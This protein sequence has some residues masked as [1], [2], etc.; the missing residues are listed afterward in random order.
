M[1]VAGS[2]YAFSPR[3]FTVKVEPGTPLPEPEEL[4]FVPPPH[5]AAAA[6]PRSARA[7][8]IRR[9]RLPLRMAARMRAI[10]WRARGAPSPSSSLPD[11]ELPRSCVRLR[12]IAV[13]MKPMSGGRG[14][15]TALREAPRAV[16]PFT[17]WGRS[18][19]VSRP[20][21]CWEFRVAAPARV[22]TLAGRQIGARLQWVGDGWGASPKC[23]MVSLGVWV[24]ARTPRRS[25]DGARAMTAPAPGKEKAPAADRGGR[26][27]RLDSGDA[28]AACW[29]WR[30]PGRG[31]RSSRT[32][33]GPCTR[34]CAR[35][36]PARP[37]TTCS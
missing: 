9:M 29:S 20:R 13:P 11:A 25:L 5:P 37:A 18:R 36:H 12:H 31:P 26:T 17:A 10:R 3:I 32:A 16:W 34:S 22:D 27:A 2:K 8:E 1:E 7:N 21:G 33:P 4:G 15:R 35:T 23:G 14:A 30:T 19:F 28:T 24:N 6:A